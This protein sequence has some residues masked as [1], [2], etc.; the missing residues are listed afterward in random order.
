MKK[1]LLLVL[2]MAG[3]GFSQSFY[4]STVEADS[5]GHIIKLGIGEVPTYI[6]VTDSL[7]DLAD[8]SLATTKA[9]QFYIFAGDTATYTTADTL[10]SD[11]TVIGKIGNVSSTKWAL[12]SAKDDGSTLYSVTIKNQR[13]TPLTF[14][15]FVPII[16]IPQQ[17]KYGVYIMPYIVGGV[18]TTVNL[19]IGT[20]K[21][22]P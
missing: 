6:M 1:I 11:T 4:T 21:V 16:G 12:L 14:N 2:L 18:G 20:M 15:N 17:K 10:A 22:I 7:T 9:V 19:K 8:S 13:T 3:I 5:L